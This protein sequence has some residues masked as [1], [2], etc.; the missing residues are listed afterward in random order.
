LNNADVEYL[1][2]GPETPD[3]SKRIHEIVAAAFGRE[4]EARLVE[5]LRADEDAYIPKLALVAEAEGELLG[6]V[7]LTHATVKGKKNEWQVLALGPL[8][9]LP[10]QQSKGIGAALTQAALDSADNLGYPLVVLL[11]H[12]TYYPRFGFESARSRGIQ[13]PVEDYADEAFMVKTLS[14][15][16]EGITGTF[17]FAPAFDEA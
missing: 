13:P 5:L 10:D 6:H 14:A 8:A 9:V 15:Y 12:P 4:S 7:M 1:V 17:A 3:D 11:G 16:D 2:I